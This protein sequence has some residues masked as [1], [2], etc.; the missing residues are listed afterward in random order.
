[1]TVGASGTSPMHVNTFDKSK[2]KVKPMMDHIIIEDGAK[3][4]AKASKHLEELFKGVK[5]FAN[6]ITTEAGKTV[7]KMADKEIDGK[8]CITAEKW[9]AYVS[10]NF[11]HANANPVN[12]YITLVDAMNSLTTYMIKE[13][14][15]QKS[16]EKAALEA[17]SQAEG[18]DGKAPDMGV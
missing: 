15:A 5:D 1:M 16:E 3:V 10:E 13:Q 9:N 4:S 11:P 12:N 14:T 2:I 8:K 18:G 7:L 6:L 17:K